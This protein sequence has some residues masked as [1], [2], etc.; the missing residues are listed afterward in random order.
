MKKSSAL[1]PADDLL[2][3]ASR[4]AV[5]DGVAMVVIRLSD[6]SL[7]AMRDRCP[8]EGARL[9]DGFIVPMLAGDE[10]GKYRL[11][12]TMLLRCPWHGY[13]FDLATGQCPAD[14][15]RARVRVYDV[16]TEDGMIVVDR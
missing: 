9:S 3:G 14:P 12:E 10:V 5:V 8:H 11:T 7:R 13:E 4:R 2:P 15:V 1:F 6:G 16:R